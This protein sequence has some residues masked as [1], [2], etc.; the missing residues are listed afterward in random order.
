[1]EKMPRRPRKQES[2]EKDPSVVEKFRWDK[3]IAKLALYYTHG[4]TAQNIGD[5]EEPVF[6]I[7]DTARIVERISKSGAPWQAWLIDVRQVY[8]W[9]DPTR[10]SKWMTLFC[11][12]WY[13][14]HVVGYFHAYVIYPDS[15]EAVRQA[16]ARAADQ[17]L[18]AQAWGESVEKH[19]H[20]GWIKPLLD[21]LGPVIQLQLAD[22]ADY[23]E[24]L[25][26]F[27]KWAWPRKTAA[28]LFFF[29]VCLLIT[30]VADMAFCMKIVSFIVGSS[31]FF[32]Y[33]IAT[34]F[35]QY[36]RLLSPGDGLC[37][38]SLRMPNGALG[39]C[40]RRG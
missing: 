14:E 1:M 37:E 39:G 7:G 18:K 36:R 31:F 28:S 29:S 19:G 30:L 27:Y 8:T 38:T 2:V 23:L 10:T 22:A 34:R 32:I 17:A 12:L 21:K 20:G 6:D 4:F 24:V 3:W 5:F 25:V 15:V 11:T 13:T 35:P 26:N 33:P 9:E 16:Y 40:R